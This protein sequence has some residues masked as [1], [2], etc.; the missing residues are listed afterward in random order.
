MTIHF[1]FYEHAK[2]FVDKLNLYLGGLKPIMRIATILFYTR[3][4]SAPYFLP[5][6]SARNR[7]AL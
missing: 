7:R 2:M 3:R 4:A 1:D 6:A 5:P